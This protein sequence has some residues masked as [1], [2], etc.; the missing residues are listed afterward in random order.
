MQT[1][2][3]LDKKDSQHVK[4]VSMLVFEMIILAVTFF[5]KFCATNTCQNNPIIRAA[6]IWL[7]FLKTILILHF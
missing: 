6:N 3:T 1:S 7:W 4:V 2:L 5:A